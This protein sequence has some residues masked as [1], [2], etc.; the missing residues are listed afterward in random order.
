MAPATVEAF[1]IGLFDTTKEGSQ[2]REHVS[3][4]LVQTREFSNVELLPAADP[5][6]Q[7]LEALAQVVPGMIPPKERTADGM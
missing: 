4:F 3:D 6:R 2:V 5:Q 1:A 7:R